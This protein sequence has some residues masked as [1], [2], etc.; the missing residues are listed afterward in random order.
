MLC[1]ISLQKSLNSLFH[2]DWV[3]QLAF[4]NHAYL[5]PVSSQTRN[6][7]K[8][9]TTIRSEFRQPKA[10]L[11][12]RK[13]CEGATGPGM[14]MPKADVHENDLPLLGENDIRLSR[15]VGNV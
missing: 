7:A 8:V 15:K 1:I 11:G 14:A 6:V 2:G 13:P 3:R 10:E 12:F 9:A 4:P 5:P